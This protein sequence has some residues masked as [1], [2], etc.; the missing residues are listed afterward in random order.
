MGKCN[1]NLL[2]NVLL[3]VAAVAAAP[4]AP[5]SELVEYAFSRIP[6]DLQ[7]QY[8]QYLL[9]GAFNIVSCK[10]CGGK[11]IKEEKKV[12]RTKADKM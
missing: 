5:R 6:R 11:G 1:G 2:Q 8:R 12:T 9:M 3:A 7:S 10:I 4:A